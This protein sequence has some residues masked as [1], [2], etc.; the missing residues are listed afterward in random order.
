MTT[1]P[2]G[3]AELTAIMQIISA[4]GGLDPEKRT[5]VLDYVFK[6]LEI[7][8]LSSAPG[9]AVERALTSQPVI[10]EAARSVSLPTGKDI[11][12]LKEEKSP[13]SANEMAALVA[14]YVSEIAAPAERKDSI[15]QQDVQRY[16]KHAGFH[17]PKVP[18]MTLP[19]AAAAG[20][21]DNI[22]DGQYR[23]NPVGY[24]LVVHN[25]PLGSGTKKS[26]TK[27]SA[28]KKSRKTKR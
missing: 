26:R 18:R 12:S 22:G 9:L 2:D 8:A 10:S 21:L 3:D 7:G 1:N 19:N 27:K 20:Y 13:R 28:K 6:R 17:L 24:N 5:R 25:L 14:Y 16:F 11:R 4:L 23:L 15:T